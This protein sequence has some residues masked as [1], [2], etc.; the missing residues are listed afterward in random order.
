MN[1][2]QTPDGWE[3]TAMPVAMTKSETT[4][5]CEATITRRDGLTTVSGEDLDA[6][7]AQMPEGYELLSVVREKTRASSRRRLDQRGVARR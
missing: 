2:A 3:I 1:E 4:L 7:R 6:V 5:T